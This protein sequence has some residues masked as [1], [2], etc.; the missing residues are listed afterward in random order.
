[1][2]HLKRN[3]VRIKNSQEQDLPSQID[4]L[5]KSI[6]TDKMKNDTN[7][8]KTEKR[9]KEIENLLI[10]MLDARVVYPTLT[11]DHILTPYSG[12]D[13]VRLIYPGPT[14]SPCNLLVHFVNQKVVHSGDMLFNGKFPY[15]MWADGSN[16][17]NRIEALEQTLAWDLNIIIPGHGD[18]TDRSGIQKKMNYLKILRTA[19]SDAI[20][21]GLSLE[22]MQNQT[23]PPQYKHLESPHRLKQSIESVYKEI[24]DK[25]P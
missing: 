7:F 5:K 21:K 24:T 6:E 25:G 16:T 3:E 1:M 10:E 22:E 23:S 18:Q 13:I 19:V 20:N 4:E 2:A 14:H 11:F 12:Q 8:A 15:I 9:V 17:K